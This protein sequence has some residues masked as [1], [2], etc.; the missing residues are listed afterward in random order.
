MNTIILLLCYCKHKGYNLPQVFYLLVNL[1]D[2]AAS[3][4]YYR[5]LQCDDGITL[6]KELEEM[7]GKKAVVAQFTLS[8]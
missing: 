3:N 4:L 8:Y 1:F 6:N 2:E 7:W 5:C